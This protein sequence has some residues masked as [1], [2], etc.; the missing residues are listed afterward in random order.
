[1]KFDSENFLQT[2]FLDTALRSEPLLYAVVGF[3]AFQR[4]LRNPAGKIQDFLEYYNKAV[5]LLLHA[6][7]KGER[8]TNGTMLAILQLA[9]IEVRYRPL[10]NKELSSNISR[11]TSVIG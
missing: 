3:A 7:K 4:T 5:S 6:L 2:K 11:S 8:H 1:M 10:P 9:T